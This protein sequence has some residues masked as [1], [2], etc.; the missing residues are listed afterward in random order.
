M[1]VQLGG[2]L[3]FYSGK[4]PTRLFV[5]L[6]HISALFY[7]FLSVPL[8]PGNLGLDLFCLKRFPRRLYLAY[9]LS[10]RAAPVQWTPPAWASALALGISRMEKA[11]LERSMSKRDVP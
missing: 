5:V 11:G 1:P 3:F 7:I 10:G 6:S 4:A 2:L 9:S 8:L